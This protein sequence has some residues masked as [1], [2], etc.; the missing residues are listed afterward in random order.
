MFQISKS[1]FEFAKLRAF[2][3]FV[4]YVPSCLPALRAFVPSRLCALCL[5]ALRALIFTRLNYTPCA[6][7]SRA[8]KC[9]K[10]SY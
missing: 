2:R 9:D 1:L 4:P 3:T 10:I 5:R 8:F 7:Y 6:P